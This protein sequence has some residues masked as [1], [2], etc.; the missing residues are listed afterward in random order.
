M[1]MLLPLV[2]LALF[3]I[4]TAFTSFNGLLQAME[5]E[6]VKGHDTVFYASLAALAIGIG[7]AV[8]LYRGK[9]SDPVRIKLFANKFYFDEIYAVIV[10]VLPG[11]PR[12]DRDR[13]LSASLSMASSRVC[14]RPSWRVSVPPPACCR[15]GICR[16]T[17]SCWAAELSP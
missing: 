16:L 15:A 4:L 12:V 13:D 5:P 7:G 1:V 11:S 8:Y 2:A 14:R 17:P 6:H 10:R 3:T 9:D